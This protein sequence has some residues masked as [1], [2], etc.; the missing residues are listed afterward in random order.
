MTAQFNE[1]LSSIECQ[2]SSVI[3]ETSGGTEKRR[4]KTSRSKRS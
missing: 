4:S 2:L 1:N 3:Q